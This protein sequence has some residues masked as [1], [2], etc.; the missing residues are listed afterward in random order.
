MENPLGHTYEY[1]LWAVCIGKNQ[2][3]RSIV[4]AIACASGVRSASVVTRL[5]GARIGAH[6]FVNGEAL[7]TKRQGRALSHLR[8]VLY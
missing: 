4:G 5:R 8:F 3:G 1:R 7:K 2:A 6:R